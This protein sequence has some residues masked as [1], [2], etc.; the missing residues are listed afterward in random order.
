MDKI[1]YEINLTRPYEDDVEKGIQ[2][3]ECAICLDNTKLTCTNW[4][5][6]KVCSH[7]FHKSCID[8]WLTNR[9]DPKCPLCLR[10]IYQKNESNQSVIIRIDEEVRER[11]ERRA[12]V[13]QVG[14][15]RE[16]QV[17]LRREIEEKCLCVCTC[18]FCLAVFIVPPI[19]MFAGKN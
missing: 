13:D 5:Q 1:P 6:L 9:V 19:M 7:T 4:V 12:R 14:E 16:R 2:R 3:E 15:D 17:I 8:T 10:E 18:L 11:L